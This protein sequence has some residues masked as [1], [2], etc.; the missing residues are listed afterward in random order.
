MSQRKLKY[1]ALLSGLIE[2]AQGLDVEVRTERLLREVGYHVHSGSCL[3]HEKRLIILDR[4][5][6]I[7]EQIDC[8]ASELRKH[9]P[10]PDQ[11]PPDLKRILCHREVALPEQ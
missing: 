11:L 6:P 4:D 10:D 3:L 9:E 7:R 2:V 5:L 8:L 1:Q